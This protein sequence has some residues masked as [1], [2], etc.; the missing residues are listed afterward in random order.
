M[1]VPDSGTQAME[2]ENKLLFSQHNSSQQQLSMEVEVP[3]GAK[4]TS[5]HAGDGDQAS[6]PG[7][8]RRGPAEAGP[9]T[10]P[11]KAAGTTAFTNRN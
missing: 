3:T 5:I 1:K 2:G 9:C 4:W 11:E 8:R 10:T 7:S 6:S